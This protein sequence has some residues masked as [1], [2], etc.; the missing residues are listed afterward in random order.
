MRGA[1]I[2]I[3]RIFP[4]AEIF[5]MPAMALA[6]CLLCPACGTKGNGSAALLTE[7]TAE[8]GLPTK[9]GHW[10]TGLYQIPEISVGGIGLFDTNGDDRPDLY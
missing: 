2:R 6:L 10:P 3:A 5:Q 9:P 7:I 1:A 8:T 4:V